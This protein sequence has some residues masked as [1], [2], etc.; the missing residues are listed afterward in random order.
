MKK[1]R[2][3]RLSKNALERR[4]KL[5]IAGGVIA[6][7][8]VAAY[9]ILRPAAGA[10]AGPP[11]PPSAQQQAAALAANCTAL[12]EQLNALRSRPNPDSIQ[13][14][15]LVSQVAQCV[16]QA[17]AAG[18]DVPAYLGQQTA[19]DQAYQQIENWFNEYKGTDYGDLLKRN[20]IRKNMLQSGAA[21]AQAYTA[22]AK[23]IPNDGAP[24]SLA[25]ASALR[26]A[27]ITALTSA[28]NRRLCYWTDQPGCGRLGVNED[29]G[30]DK[31][32]QEQTQVIDP[33]M[34]AHYFAV[35]NM[36]GTNNRDAVGNDAF[37]KA[38]LLPCSGAKAYLDAKFNEY[39][40]VDYADALRRNNIRQ[41]LLS[42]GR[43]MSA[44]LQRATDYAEDYHYTPAMQNLAKL[45]LAALDSAYAR[46][47][48]YLS[49]QPGCDRFG[50]NEDHGD[51]KAGQE[52]DAT[53]TPLVVVYQRIATY[54]VYWNV[55]LAA[56]EPLVA[57]QLKYGDLLNRLTEAKF[58]EYKATDYSDAI[59]RN[60]QRQDILKFG[61]WTAYEL[62]SAMVA[63]ITGGNG[64]VRPIIAIA[65][66][67]QPGSL[68]SPALRSSLMLGLRSG[69]P[70]STATSGLGQLA[71]RPA[72]VA[73]APLRPATALA[74]STG[75]STTS[76]PD[77]NA[78][79]NAK[80]VEI[81]R[82]MVKTVVTATSAALDQAISRQM[83]YLRGD[84]GCGTMLANEDQGPD[85]AG[86][87]YATTV[88]PMMANLA[89]GTNWLVA[90]GDAQGEV[91][92]IKT[93]LRYCNATKDY[94][95]AKF[96]E[97]RSVDWGDALRRNNLRV[98]EVLGSGRSMV[99]CYA[100]IGAATPAGRQLVKT[101]VD[102]AIVASQAR[103]GCYN[104]SSSNCGRFL[105]NEDDNATK[106]A[107]ETDDILNPLKALSASL[108]SAGTS[109]LGDTFAGLSTGTWVGIGIAAVLGGALL[110]GR[111]REKRRRA[112][113]R[114]NGRRVKRTSRGKRN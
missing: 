55:D 104:D 41:D 72:P 11:P 19:G 85:K 107:Q 7:G 94:I 64:R 82:R 28:S 33:L 31:A 20:N 74:P 102:A 80:I 5:L 60:N 61:R 17:Q 69:Q 87:E 34:G 78:A 38:M 62:G 10:S 26:S 23:Q 66:T 51:D 53:I 73:L 96:A 56:F 1:K 43:T 59:K 46:W 47:L 93:K 92:L 29:H 105:S 42:I 101:A 52:R 27:I 84:S 8:G 37:F 12:Q 108:A 89:D 3:R 2:T 14:A 4:T 39:K 30:N 75:T 111:T 76:R 25:A 40:S 110:F 91:A 90:H 67:L 81:G 9:A 22:A 112:R 99:A 88:A 24:A 18:A 15:R 48:C 95:D 70:A 97:Y 68:L 49:A 106:A 63:A 35:I 21:M 71:V 83:C 45:T 113:P 65:A 100:A 86:Q 103:V 32:A 57:M 13:V 36:G 114:R 58:N 44:C 79:L 6:A 109:G 54:L 77:P 50:V 16:Q 98:N